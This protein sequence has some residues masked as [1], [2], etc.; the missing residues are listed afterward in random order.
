[1]FIR[2]V[3]FLISELNGRSVRFEAVYHGNADFDVAGLSLLSSSSLIGNI[4]QDATGV[5]P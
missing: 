1:M 5:D 4:D 3:T 2:P